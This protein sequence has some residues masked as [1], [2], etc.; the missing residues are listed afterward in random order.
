MEKEFNLSEKMFPHGNNYD[1][2]ILE[3]DVKE[4]IKKNKEDLENMNLQRGDIL[5]RMLERAG[6]KLK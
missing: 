3:K 6:D 2:V 1:I 5:R 4:F